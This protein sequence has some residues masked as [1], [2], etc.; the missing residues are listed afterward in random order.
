MG[1]IR[2]KVINKKVV[3]VSLLIPILLAI[4]W[5]ILS[6]DFPGVFASDS[7]PCSHQLFSEVLAKNVSE[8]GLVNY[9]GIQNNRAKFDKYINLL[10][11]HHPNDKYW[12]YQEQKAYWINAYNAFTI[13]LIL[14]NYPVKSIKDLGGFIYR[15]NTPWDIKFIS[16]EGVKYD[17]NNIEHDILRDK[18]SDPRIHFALNCASKSCPALRNEAY[19]ALQLDK[20][21]DQAAVKFINDLDRNILTKNEVN[22][23]KIFDWFSSDFEKKGS[24]IEFLNYYS[25]IKLSDQASIHYLDYN[26]ELNESKND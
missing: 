18:F 17:L 15:I 3:L 24:L 9:Q 25:K 22:I 5:F 20:Q 7:K 13:Q 19:D 8:D 11:T 6:H 2:K 26:W 21:L 12:T 4:S 1:E 16:I 23:S 14:D 10:S